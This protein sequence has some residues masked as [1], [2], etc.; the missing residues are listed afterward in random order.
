MN[1]ETE[2]KTTEQMAAEAM[3]GLFHEFRHDIDELALPTLMAMAADKGATRLLIEDNRAVGFLMVIDGY[4]EGI[5]VQ[6]EYRRKGIA[7][8]AVL[9]YLRDFPFS[10]PEEVIRTLHIVNANKA[11][12]KF[13]FSIFDMHKIDSNPVDKLYEVDGLKGRWKINGMPG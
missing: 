4:V 12:R 11:A 1:D 3:R 6:P 9:D 5:Y 13:W 7:R 2:K 8:R 10:P